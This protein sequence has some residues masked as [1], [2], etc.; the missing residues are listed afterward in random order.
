MQIEKK[1]SH[2]ALILAHLQKNGTITKA[3]AYKPEFNWCMCLAQR[4]YDLRKEGWLIVKEEPREKGKNYAVYRL[5]GRVEEGGPD[6][7]TFK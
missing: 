1:P 6:N 5:L 3:Q 2:K 7:D 4:I